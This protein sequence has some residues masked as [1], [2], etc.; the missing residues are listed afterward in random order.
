L[1][2]GGENRALTVIQ[3]SRQAFASRGPLIQLGSS[4]LP[5]KAREK[6]I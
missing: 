5:T 4:Q 6:R 2:A 3:R 1:H